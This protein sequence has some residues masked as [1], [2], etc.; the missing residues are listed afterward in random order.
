MEDA[1]AIVKTSQF[2]DPLIEEQ[3]KIVNALVNE[4]NTI[5]EDYE[6]K[7]IKFAF[8]VR[9]I[10]KGCPDA[11]VK[12]IIEKVKNHPDIKVSASKSRIIDGMRVIELFPKL[13]WWTGLSAEQKKEIPYAEKPYLKRDGNIFYEFYFELARYRIDP[14]IAHELA[15]KGKNNLWSSRKTRSE[16]NKYLDTTRDPNTFRRRQKQAIIKEMLI[17]MKDLQPD[18][19]TK[20]KEFAIK[21]YDEKLVNYKLWLT[22]KTEAEN[23]AR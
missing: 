4:W 5:I 11:T 15:E 17:I 8:K 20:I 10:L 7:S 13:Q 12:E 2:L 9:E 6:N 14:G 21:N 1:L 23:N 18:D 22:A 19:L 3:D 16:I